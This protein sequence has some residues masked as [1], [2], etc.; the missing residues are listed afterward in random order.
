[1]EHL[2]KTEGLDEAAV[3]WSNKK[4]LEHDDIRDRASRA[5]EPWG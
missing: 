3:A 2:P 5:H 1:M 4:S